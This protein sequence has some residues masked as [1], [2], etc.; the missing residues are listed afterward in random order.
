MNS[1]RG[2]SCNTGRVLLAGI[3]RTGSGADAADGA[4][5]LCNGSLAGGR[6]GAFLEYKIPVEPF[7]FMVGYGAAAFTDVMEAGSLR[8]GKSCQ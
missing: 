5:D 4:G 1:D 7:A 3:D 8:Y 6:I 2:A